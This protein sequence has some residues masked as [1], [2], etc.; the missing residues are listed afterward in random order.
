MRRRE[1]S[2]VSPGTPR[3]PHGSSWLQ[4]TF[5]SVLTGSACA[6]F[7]RPGGTTHLIARGQPNRHLRRQGSV[8][9]TRIS[10][11]YLLQ[12]PIPLPGTAFLV[13]SPRRTARDRGIKKRPAH[14]D[15]ARSPSRGSPHPRRAL[16]GASWTSPARTN[17][18]RIIHRAV[19][20]AR[21][22]LGFGLS[23]FATYS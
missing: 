15:T 22:T 10:H 17:M 2:A 6:P 23:R 11:E 5:S 20:L 18:A 12:Q 8:G 19:R 7:E 9:L 3:L 14:E 1:S 4:Y 13:R 21:A 16:F